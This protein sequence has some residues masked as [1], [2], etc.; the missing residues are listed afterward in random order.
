MF[1]EILGRGWWTGRGTL[2]LT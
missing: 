1:D 2:S